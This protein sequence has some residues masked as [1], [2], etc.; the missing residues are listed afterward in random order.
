MVKRQRLMLLVMSAMMPMAYGQTTVV[1]V[2]TPVVISLDEAIRRAEVNEPAFAASLADSR[3]AQL[4]K[5]IARA[6]LLPSATIHNEYL[7]TQ[8]NGSADRIGQTANSAA[9]RFI[10]NN[11]VHEYA[12]VGVVNETVGLAQ[13]GAVTQI[14]RAHV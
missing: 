3:S 4:D 2:A 5:S 1:P 14:G 10:A 11:A 9:P 7:F 13:F 12:S 6:G 8:G